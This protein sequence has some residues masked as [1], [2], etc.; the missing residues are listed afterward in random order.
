MKLRPVVL[1]LLLLSGFY[2]VTTRGIASGRLF[3]SLHVDRGAAVVRGLAVLPDSP[4][5]QFHLTEGFGC[6]GAGV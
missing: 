5:G 4:A 2:Y 3:P 6:G 1:V